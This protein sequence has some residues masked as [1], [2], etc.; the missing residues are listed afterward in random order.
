MGF[1]TDKEMPATQKITDRDVYL[2]V[3]EMQSDLAKVRNNPELNLDKDVDIDTYT[4]IIR[5][6]FG[7]FKDGLAGSPL[8]GEN[9]IFSKPN[10]FTINSNNFSDSSML[11]LL[12][13]V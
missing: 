5:A 9:P 10:S 7:D 12:R 6:D 13:T 4:D 11:S 1:A 2:L 3:E 8:N